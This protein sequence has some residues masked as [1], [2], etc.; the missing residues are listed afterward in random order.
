LYFLSTINLKVK[1]F[2]LQNLGSISPTY[3]RAAFMCKDP[4]RKTL[5]SCHQCLFALLDLGS[6]SSTLYEQLLRMQIPKGQKR[7][8]S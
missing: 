2:I 8:S 1:S 6:I 7:Q 3:L 4:K 5:Q